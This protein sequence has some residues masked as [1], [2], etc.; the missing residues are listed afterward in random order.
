MAKQRK[1]V[2]AR[3]DEKGRTTHVLFDNNERFTPVEKAKPIVERGEV[4][5][6]HIVNPK[7]KES[8]IR[9]NPDRSQGN[10]LDEMSGDK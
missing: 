3:S 1:I 8:F 2:G 7:G 9:T 6:A 10:N 4:A 5:N